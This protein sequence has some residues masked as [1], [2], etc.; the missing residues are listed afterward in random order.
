MDIGHWVAI[1]AALVPTIGMLLA[2]RAEGAAQVR[3]K[4]LEVE[5]QRKD[6]VHREAEGIWQDATAWREEQGRIIADLGRTIAALQARVLALE[7]QVRE[8]EEQDRLRAI[9]LETLQRAN[10]QQAA[11]IERLRAQGCSRAPDC[12]EREPTNGKGGRKRS[13]AVVAPAIA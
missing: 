9:E 2:K 11:E 4:S 12:E 13:V 7:G 5:L 8:H 6:L 1:A 10:E 3:I